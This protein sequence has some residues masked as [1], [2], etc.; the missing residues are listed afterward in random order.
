MHA[1]EAVGLQIIKGTHLVLRD[2]SLYADCGHVTALTGPSGSG[3]TSLLRVLAFIDQPTSGVVRLWGESPN[4]EDDPP[5]VENVSIYPVVVY[6]PQ[7]LALWPHLTI[8]NNLSFA[9][10]SRSDDELISTSDDLEISDLLDRRPDR[11]SQGQRQRAALARALVLKPKLLLLDEVTSAL[12]DRL[13]N[14]VW[15]ILK[16]FAKSGAAV[17]ASTH[18]SSLAQQCDNIYCIRDST[19]ASRCSEEV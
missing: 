9:R 6:V 13:A 7:T 14:K 12:D 10:N 15:T 19:L 1:L 11:L 17:L 18:D 4:R 2:S 3:K 8:R 5:T 16:E